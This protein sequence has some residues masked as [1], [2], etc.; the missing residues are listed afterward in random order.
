MEI[1]ITTPFIRLDAAL[2]LS[3][4]VLSGGEAK[5]LVQAGKVA[6]NG[7]ICTQRGRKLV[8]G[9]SITVGSSHITVA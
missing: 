3:G 4:A 5:E 6:V 7:G 2:K 8:T 9:D 1:K